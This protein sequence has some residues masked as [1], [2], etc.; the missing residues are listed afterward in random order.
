MATGLGRERIPLLMLRSTSKDV[1]MMNGYFWEYISY[2]SG[3]YSTTVSP[4]EQYGCIMNAKYSYNYIEGHPQTINLLA[5]Y[6]TMKY[7]G[8]IPIPDD[9]ERT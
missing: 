3:R 4:T 1:G 2:R 5:A 6:A 7:I 8:E 9:I